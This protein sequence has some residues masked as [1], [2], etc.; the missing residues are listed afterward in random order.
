MRVRADL[1]AAVIG[2]PHARSGEAPKAF[3]VRAPNHLNMTAEDGVGPRALAGVGRAPCPRVLPVAVIASLRGRLAEYK[4]IAEVE[5]VDS[6]PKS[7]SGKILRK[8][9][10]AREV[11]KAAKGGHKHK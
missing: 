3:V 6:L 7:A 11:A 10:R 4:Q 1:A 5:F 8:D 2:V 9:L